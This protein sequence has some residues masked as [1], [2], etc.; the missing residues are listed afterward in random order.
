MFC[1]LPLGEF[2]GGIL[3]GGGESSGPLDEV[4][5][6]SCLRLTLDL[7]INTQTLAWNYNTNNLGGL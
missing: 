4:G 1:R 7:T 2:F 3:Y 6:E 5:E